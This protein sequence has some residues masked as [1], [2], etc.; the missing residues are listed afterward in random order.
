M[1]RN[2]FRQGAVVETTLDEVFEEYIQEKE[3]LGRS[4]DTIRNYR[5]SYKIFCDYYDI[6]AEKTP[7]DRLEEKMFYQWRQSMIEREIRKQS[8]NHYLRDWRTFLNWCYANGKMKEAIKIKEAKVQ[9]DL[10]KMYTDEELE[11]L[12]THPRTGDV[13]TVWRDWCI[14]NLIYSTGL[15]ASSVCD[16]T[17]D[18]L[19]FDKGFLTIPSQKNKKA[20]MLPITPALEHTLKDYMKKWLSEEPEEAYLFQTI[21]GDKLSVNA[22]HQSIDRYCKLYNVKG[23]GVHSIRHNF[24]RDMIL[25]GGGEY[26]LQAYLQHSNIQMSQHYVKLFSGDLKRD[27]EVYNPLDRAKQKTSRTSKFKK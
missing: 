11:A 15:R 14:I 17:I 1:A 21:K 24:A 10:P 20:G 26:R 18:C 5:L 4:K 3:N 25:N 27:A 2:K 13:Y 12:L 9:E 23:H 19:D 22:L 7:I 8:I 16:L 6:D